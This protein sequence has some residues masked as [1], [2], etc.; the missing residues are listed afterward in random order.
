VD[1]RD[2]VRTPL[3]LEV[4]DRIVSTAEER[5]EPPSGLAVYYFSFA[6]YGPL[7]IWSSRKGV[8]VGKVGSEYV[9]LRFCR[10]GS[11][12]LLGD[13]TSRDPPFYS[14][15]ALGSAPPCST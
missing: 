4:E 12:P 11:L 14:A 2:R 7:I 13:L 15:F 1:E 6:I 3:R 8:V 9:F 10:S 5:P